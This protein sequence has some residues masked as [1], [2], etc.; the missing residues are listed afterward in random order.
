MS[1]EINLGRKE[2]NLNSSFICSEV[3]IEEVLTKL[4][5]LILVGHLD[6]ALIQVFRRSTN[7]QLKNYWSRCANCL[8]GHWEVARLIFRRFTRERG[9]CWSKSCL[10]KG[11]LGIY[12]LV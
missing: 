8:W 3:R 10:R 6:K 1:T 5:S 11:N 12:R 7:V 9:G 4:V 2:I